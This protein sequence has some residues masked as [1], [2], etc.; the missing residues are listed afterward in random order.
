MER[1]GREI[2]R[3]TQPAHSQPTASPQGDQW[4]D[5]FPYSLPSLLLTYRWGFL[6]AEPIT[7]WEGEEVR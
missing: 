4:W 5:K 7:K 3:D 1:G 6:V 2:T